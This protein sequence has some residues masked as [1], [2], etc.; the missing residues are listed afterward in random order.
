VEAPTAFKHGTE[1]LATFLWIGSL[2]FCAKH[3]LV[4]AIS[5]QVFPLNP[6]VD[7]HYIPAQVPQILHTFQDNLGVIRERHAY[8]AKSVILSQGDR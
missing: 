7:P 4:S 3:L 1:K 5:L 6:A 2:L 8:V